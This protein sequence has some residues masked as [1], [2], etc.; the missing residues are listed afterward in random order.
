MKSS[1]LSRREFS[2]LTM[3]AFGGVVAGTAFGPARAAADEAEL[4]REP[5]VCRGLNT[6]RG[7]G[8]CKTAKNDCKGQNDCAGTGA[9]ASAKHHTC[10]GGNDCRGQGGCGANPGENS[11]KGEGKCAV[12]LMDDAWKAARANFE[13]AM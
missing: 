6:C 5:H 13:K 2:K 10:A 1:E 8:A 4:L 11:C 12:P 3:A 9:C 7:L